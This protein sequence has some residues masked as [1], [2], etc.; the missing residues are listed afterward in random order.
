MNIF[1]GII[2]DPS[3]ADIGWMNNKSPAYEYGYKLAA[4]KLSKGFE[5]LDSRDKDSLIFPIIFLY[6]QHIELSLKSLIRELDL[7]LNHNR[8]DKIL[9]R[10]KLLPLWDECEKQYNEY[11]QQNSI[12]LIFTSTKTTKE[13]S[14]INEFDKLDEDSFSFR[15]STDKNG[16]DN[17]KNVDFISLNNFQEHINTVNEHIDN[18]IETLSHASQETH[19]KLFKWDC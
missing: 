4:Q 1:K 7:M 3:N 6:R 16:T 11:I 12:S 13:R 5:L 15:Y 2:Q 17:L 14:I 19:N 10:H 9:G 18:V 8:Q